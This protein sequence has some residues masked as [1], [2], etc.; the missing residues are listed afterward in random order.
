MYWNVYLGKLSRSNKNIGF[1]CLH[2]HSNSKVDDLIYNVEKLHRNKN[3]A[4]HL[5]GDFNINFLSY[6]YNGKIMDF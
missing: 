4:I 3:N 2:I 1:P 5:F 6:E